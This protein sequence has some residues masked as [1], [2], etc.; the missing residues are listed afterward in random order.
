MTDIKFQPSLIQYFAQF[1]IQAIEF[2]ILEKKWK[3]K[4][5]N[6]NSLRK[7][8][9]SKT[10][11]VL[12]SFEKYMKQREI[13]NPKLILIYSQSVLLV[14]DKTNGHRINKDM[15]NLSNAMNK[16]ELC[17]WS[18][19]STVAEYTFFSSSQET[20]TKTDHNLG[21]ER[22]FSKFEVFD[23]SGLY[24]HNRIK[25]E[26]NSR[27]SLKNSQMSRNYTYTLIW[28]TEQSKNQ[29]WNEEIF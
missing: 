16:P 21:H 1:K 2:N 29:K 14:T 20:F 3:L 25:L 26:I 13:T 5:K 9:P 7:Y 18:Y 27:K 23:H 12:E 11:F 8:V 22:I 6:D 17:D 19:H 24:D 15:E 4:K 28:P 10:H